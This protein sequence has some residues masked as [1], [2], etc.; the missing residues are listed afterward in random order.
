MSVKRCKKSLAKLAQ[1]VTRAAGI[2]GVFD[3]LPHVDNLEFV[4]KVTI[5]LEAVEDIEEAVKR[6]V[7][8][9]DSDFEPIR[10]FIVDE[11]D[12]LPIFVAELKPEVGFV[13]CDAEE[14]TVVTMN[15]TLPNETEGCIGKIQHPSGATIYKVR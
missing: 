4:R 10:F 14:K 12:G 8:H 1:K 9:N 15:I 13:V 5:R 3:E 11:N 7:F 6:Y 2:D